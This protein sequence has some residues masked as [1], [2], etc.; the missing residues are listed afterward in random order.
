MKI[1]EM[2]GA[3]QILCDRCGVSVKGHPG[4]VVGLHGPDICILHA[5]CASESRQF[6][7]NDAD[8]Q[9]ALSAFLSELTTAAGL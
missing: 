3:L 7:R 9:I 8:R 4:A 5:G 2:S 1:T 6:L